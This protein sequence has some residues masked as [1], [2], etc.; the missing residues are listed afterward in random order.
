M[1]GFLFD[2]TFLSR[3]DDMIAIVQ[4]AVYICIITTIFILQTWE[5]EWIHARTPSWFHKAWGYRDALVHFCFGTLLNVYTLFFFKS[6]SLS[7]SI[8]FMIVVAALIIANEL[9]HLRRFGARFQSVLLTL[10]LLGFWT[11]LIPLIMGFIGLIPFLISVAVSAVIVYR[12]FA[13]LRGWGHDEKRL[14]KDILL[15]AS[16]VLV[17]YTGFYFLGWI[18]PVPLALKKSGIYHDIKKSEDTYQLYTEKPS[19]KF[20]Q[21]GDQEFYARPGDKIYFYARIFTPTRIKDQIKVRWMYKD[22]RLGWQNA[23]AIPM[24]IAGGREEGYRGYAY[25]ANYMP[26]AWRVQVESSDGREIGRLHF[27]VIP[28]EAEAGERNFSIESD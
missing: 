5:E 2:V 26:G 8:G 7:A 13:H 24:N 23:D 10:C 4:Q 20:W 27:Q 12:I 19:W 11:I 14:V 3:V 25:K 17:L 6:S 15:P 28:E 16:G 1:C 22:A 21:S 18:P 9:P